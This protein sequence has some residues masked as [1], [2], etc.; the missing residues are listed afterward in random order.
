MH[1]K[2]LKLVDR[3][4]CNRDLE[5]DMA[6]G[7]EQGSEKRRKRAWRKPREAIGP[8]EPTATPVP[9]KTCT[10]SAEH[11]RSR[12][13]EARQD[14]R[15]RAAP[16]P[17]RLDARRTSRDAAP[18]CKSLLE[19]DGSMMEGVRNSGLAFYL[20]AISFC[21]YVQTP[22]KIVY[23]YVLYSINSAFFEY[24]LENV[25]GTN[26]LGH[27]YAHYVHVHSLLSFGTNLAPLLSVFVV[28][29]MTSGSLNRLMKIVNFFCGQAQCN[30][31]GMVNFRVGCKTVD[32][33]SV[34][35]G[36][37]FIQFLCFILLILIKSHMAKR[38][39]V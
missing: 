21:N 34:D 32:I 22:L 16:D 15:S 30:D 38:L 23:L 17:A 29:R 11:E 27:L 25:Y 7:G 31:L 19:I 2:K 14:A 33:L 24:W 28:M 8:G 35:V 1:T 3:F 39:I 36:L 18:E 6:S 5:V 12:Q 37:A 13:A 20:E 4:R 9:L 10:S 26:S